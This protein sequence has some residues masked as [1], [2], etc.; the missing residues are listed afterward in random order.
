MFGGRVVAVAEESTVVI[1]SSYADYNSDVLKRLKLSPTLISKGGFLD[2]I[3]KVC[4]QKPWTF[5]NC[6]YSHHGK[7]IVSRLT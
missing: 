5:Q 4:N 3:D 1:A 2:V 7:G 6:I